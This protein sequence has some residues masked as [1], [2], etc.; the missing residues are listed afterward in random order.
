MQQSV[1]TPGLMARLAQ[2]I[3]HQPTTPAR[4]KRRHIVYMRSVLLVALGSVLIAGGAVHSASAGL[5]LL[6]AMAATI[7]MFALTPIRWIRFIRFE[8]YVGALDLTFVAAA[9]Y[10]SG[11]ARGVLPVSVLLMMLVVA[12]ASRRSQAVAAGGAVAMIHSWLYLSMSNGALSALAPQIVFV[13]AI[14]FY[15]GYLV[16]GTHQYR[17]RSEAE[18]LERHELAVLLEILDSITSSLDLNRVTQRI[19]Q[20]VIDVI[21][22]ARCSMLFVDSETDRCY[23]IASHGFPDSRMLEIDLVQYPEVKR[24][25]ETREPVLIS[26]VDQ[27][28]TMAAA[29]EALSDVDLHSIMVVPMIFGDDVLGTIVMKASR[30]REN[31]TLQELRFCSA[32]A[33]ASANGLKN[34]LL[35]RQAQDEVR[36]QKQTNEKLERIFN[37]SPELI[38]TTDCTRH[39]TSFNPAAARLLAYSQEEVE[40]MNCD[41][42]FVEGGGRQLLGQLELEDALID[43]PCRLR[44]KDGGEIDVEL[45]L[46]A[47]RDENGD[48][49]GTV[50]LGRDVSQLKATRTQLLQAK[51]LSTIGEIIAG[52]AHELNNP[53][54]GVLGFSELLLLRAGCDETDREL[55]MIRDSAVRCQKIVSSLLSFARENKPERTSCSINDAIAEALAMKRYQLCSHGVKIETELSDELPATMFDYQQL[56]QVILSLIGNAQKAMENKRDRESRL[57]ISSSVAGQSIRIE[58]EDS[59][60]GMNQET[61]ERIFD[62]F[63]TTRRPGHG[64]GLGLSVAYGVIKEHGGRIW[65]S[66]EIGQ[67]STIHIELPFC[68]APTDGDTHSLDSPVREPTIRE[69]CRMLVVD[70]EPV[71]LELLVDLY[72]GRGYRVDTAGN[73]K[74]ALEKLCADS[75]DL[76]ISDI[77]MP[78]MGGVELYLRL[79]EQSPELR[80]RI[81]MMTGDVVDHETE[82][83]LEAQGATLIHKPLEVRE[84]VSAVDQILS[85][86]ALSS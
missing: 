17:R 72:Q 27:D 13:A 11:A 46:S 10:L 55:Q 74:E 56:Q 14:G 4:D 2:Q 31:F 12:V 65:A 52:V 34:A 19:V 16:Q 85:R 23:V 26:D 6:I 64:T 44:R 41:A 63:F 76:V 8:A 35:H 80:D 50:W 60:V 37:H 49:L 73:G 25:I 86:A 62:P 32:V 58:I 61:L 18:Q 15:F 7:V 28:P 70:D 5:A 53:L 57:R 54:S 79:L 59:G 75:Y 47:F 81:L 39:I 9:I 1:E 51:K 48:V 36:H 42:L 30:A 40:G 84:L 3:G 67:G 82:S 22:D 45:S 71:V 78:E 43:R 29:R 21:P 68:E 38:I 83:F 24:A 33:G 77:R 69:G 20:K 66:S